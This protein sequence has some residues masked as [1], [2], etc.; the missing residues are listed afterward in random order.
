MLP[1]LDRRGARQ[2]GV[3]DAYGGEG[4]Q[5]WVDATMFLERGSGGPGGNNPESIRF[6]PLDLLDPRSALA[7]PFPD[8]GP[9]WWMP[10]AVTGPP[11]VHLS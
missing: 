1:S 2:G 11:L 4:V 5:Q 7:L 10:P 3:I 9:G 6:H 8:R